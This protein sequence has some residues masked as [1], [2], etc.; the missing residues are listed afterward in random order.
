MFDRLFYSLISLWSY[1]YRRAGGQSNC[2]SEFYFSH[3]FSDDIDDYQEETSFGTYFTEEAK[4]IMKR[5]LGKKL[6]GLGMKCEISNFL[7]EVDDIGF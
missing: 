2:F 5:R 4:T 1:T 7:T 6:F 3:L